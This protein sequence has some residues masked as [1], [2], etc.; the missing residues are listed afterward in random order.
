MG[1]SERVPTQLRGRR[2]VLRP[3]TAN[4][5]D[6]WREV[7][8]R[9]RGWLLK[10]EPTPPLGQPDDTESR[11][12]FVARCGAREREW[13][14]GTGYGF[15]IFVDGRF[16][17]EINLSGVQRGPFQNTYVGYWIDEAEAGN[18]YVPESLVV[19]ARF[20]FEDLGLHRLQVAIIPRNRSSRR[21]VE[22]LQLR[23]EGVAQRYLAI[24]GVWE[25]HIRFAMTSEEWK[26]RR[27][28]LLYRWAGETQ[29]PEVPL[30]PRP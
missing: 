10:W 3:L 13:Q 27:T 11:P 7:R 17:G 18:G 22:K 8:R 29:H 15:G 1:L 30:R 9:N 26:Q 14:L 20:V 5:F 2:V 23:E 21:V 4:D 24:N 12:A 19:A 28:E 6:A 25:D 16:A